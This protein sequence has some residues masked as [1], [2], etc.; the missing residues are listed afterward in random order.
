MTGEMDKI[1]V[2]IERWWNASTANLLVEVRSLD[3]SGQ[4][5][6]PVLSTASMPAQAVPND[7]PT[8]ADI[9]LAP[10]APVT[11][12]TRYALVLSSGASVSYSWGYTNDIYSGGSGMFNGNEDTGF[13]WRETNG[14][15][16]FKTYVVPDTAAPT[17]TATASPVPNAAGWNSSEVS[18]ALNATDEGGSGV[19]EITYS[20]TNDGQQIAGDTVLGGSVSVP[21]T[22]EGENTF[23]Y[24]AM[25]S[26]GNV[27]ADK[28]LTIKLD[29]TAPTVSSTTPDH[30]E[31]DVR[32]AVKPRATF[33]D[34]MDQATV[35]NSSVKLYQ[36]NA[37]K[38]TWR[39]MPVAVSADGD[40]VILNPYPTDSSRLLAA[41]K[42]YKAIITSAAEN[43]A[44][45][46]LDQDPDKPGNQPKVWIFST[47]R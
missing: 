2:Y 34:G 14:D 32:L 27:E 23:T 40:T 11:A 30:R 13:Q 4:P 7:T 38:E 28:T 1:S 9:S 37:K 29:K 47:R 45:I 24:H 22:A 43:L 25:D 44:N 42:K 17:T 3:S 18:V 20:V 36:W 35:S 41:S 39:R 12:G 10:G 19:K 26:A 31:Q 16:L 46:P 21:V 15:Q 33:S 5:T 6:G 8:W